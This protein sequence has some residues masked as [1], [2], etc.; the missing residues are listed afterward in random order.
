MGNLGVTAKKTKNGAWQAWHLGRAY[1]T[2]LFR[3]Y[4]QD[5]SSQFGC[6]VIEQAV[7][8][9]PLLV[10]HHEFQL[11]QLHELRPP[12]G[13]QHFLRVDDGIPWGNENRTL[14]TSHK[15]DEGHWPSQIHEN[16]Q[17]TNE[18]K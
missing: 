9:T 17:F 4:I 16:P 8:W 7:P 13:T 2:H 10:R 6:V 11:R 15:I 18:Y 1:L 14:G 3:G 5:Y 12:C